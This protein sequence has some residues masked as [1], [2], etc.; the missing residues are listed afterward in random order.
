MLE[1]L[2]APYAAARTI[3]V[4]LPGPPRKVRLYSA[5]KRAFD[6]AVVLA[7]A[8]FALALVFGIAL[9]V[10]LDG[11]RAFYRQQR[12]GRNGRT[13]TIWKLRTMVPD[14]EQRLA[15]YLAVN[16]DARR[17]WDKTQKLRNDPRITWAGGYLRK[18]SL[19]ELPQ[20]FNVLRGDMSLIGPRPICVDQRRLY[21]GTAYYALRPGLTGLWQVHERNNCSFA[22]RAG[23]DTRYAEELSLSLDMRILSKTVLVVARGTGL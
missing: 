16:P 21:P 4:V 9:V 15:E 5:F 8:P 6:L 23:Y 3:D 1:R 18:Y 19:D 12:L 7:S 20:L 11:G 22:E 13:F 17:E 10:R 2:Q 14:A